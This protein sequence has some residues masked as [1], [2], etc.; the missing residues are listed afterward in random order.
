MKQ[1][2]DASTLV[3]KLTVTI[4]LMMNGYF[5]NKF[6]SLIDEECCIKMVEEQSGQRPR[7]I[8]VLNC[9]RRI[10]SMPQQKNL[11]IKK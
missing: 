4:L 10:H 7:K 1:I 3:K 6:F 8:R 2:E 11:S 9:K 5:L